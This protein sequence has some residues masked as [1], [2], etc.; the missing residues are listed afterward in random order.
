MDYKSEVPDLNC[1][2]G[3]SVWLWWVRGCCCATAKAAF[4]LLAQ[5]SRM[6]QE[7]A[8]QLLSCPLPLRSSSQ[9][10]SHLVKDTIY[11]VS[12][13]NTAPAETAEA[14]AYGAEEESKA[15]G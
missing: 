7:L 1:C 14:S 6:W 8:V 15:R 2:L 10:L 9:V 5:G 13:P 12:F 3:T 11:N 4:V